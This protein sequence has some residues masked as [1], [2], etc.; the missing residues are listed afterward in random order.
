MIIK[1]FVDQGLGNS[2]YLVGS[3]EDH[4]AV[5]I[6][7]QRN[8]DSYLKTA[9]ELG[10]RITH[11]LETHLHA[12]FASGS[13]ELAARTGAHIGA[14]ARANLQFHH[15]SLKE[16]DKIRIGT[17][18]IQVLD[19]PGHSP[20]HISFLVTEKGSADPP[21]LFSGGALTVGGA[22]RTD[23]QGHEHAH[24]LAH[25][26]YHTIHGKLMPLPEKTIVFPTHGA[27]SFCVSAGDGEDVDRATT[28]GH[29]K[30]NNPLMKADKE[31]DFIRLALTGLPSYP[32]YFKRMASY[33]KNGPPILGDLPAPPPLS[34][35]EVKRMI[36]DKGIVVDA[37]PFREFA[38]GHVPGAISNPFRDSFASYL[39]WV[40]PP[41]HPLIIVPGTPE[42]LEPIVRQAIGIG[43]DDLAGYLQGGVKAWQ[44]TG[45]P[46]ARADLTTP[47]EVY[48]E[49]QKKTI[50]VLDVRQ[51]SEW[52][53]GHIPGAMHIE[54]GE[55]EKRIKE[56]PA[57]STV[58]VTC[59]M[60]NRSS[61][62][63]SILKK[64]GYKKVKNIAGGFNR[65]TE[66]R[67]PIV[68]G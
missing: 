52:N 65:W 47:E 59:T 64:A 35:S 37:R 33:N 55:L 22:G 7:P 14:S 28:I 61:T 13:R 15:L 5:V 23:L 42:Q 4:V 1:Q 54:L 41:D 53:A 19:T 12:D 58:A 43:Y 66:A 38:A 34:P 36:E 60:G 31:E 11:A 21:V 18:V 46:V 10:L 25:D 44:D 45:F 30:L 68:K 2:S 32:T 6:D 24:S 50:T 48:Q 51:D 9:Q 17:L 27:G 26:L 39:G 16:K 62:A 3:T 20:E 8:I 29:E 56:V 40:V 67:L 57:D 63:V 49:L